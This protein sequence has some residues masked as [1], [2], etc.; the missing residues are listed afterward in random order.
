LSDADGGAAKKY[1]KVLLKHGLA[2]EAKAVYANIAE[3]SS[4]GEAD[5]QQGTD[6]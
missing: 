3:A 1:A 6:A 2:S 4:Q 5:S